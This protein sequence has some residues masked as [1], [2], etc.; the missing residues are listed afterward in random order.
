MS[1]VYRDLKQLSHDLPFEVGVGK[2]P[3]KV[4]ERKAKAKAS[5]AKMEARR[6]LVPIQDPNTG[7]ATARRKAAQRKTGRA[8]T[9]LS[10]NKETLG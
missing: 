6:R 4:E 5:E 10:G 1:S 3:E 7:K 9:I 8:S 2:E